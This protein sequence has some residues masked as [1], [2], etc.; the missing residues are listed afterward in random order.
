MDDFLRRSW[1]IPFVAVTAMAV[2]VALLNRPEFT[3][4]PAIYRSR[5]ELLFAGNA[6]Y[7]D[8]YFEHLPLSLVPMMAA[9]LL[10]GFAGDALFTSIFA[11][12]MVACLVGCARAVDEDGGRE[13]GLRWLLLAGPLFPIVIFRSDPFP[14]VLAA[15]AFAA[16]VAGQEK[17]AGGLEFAGVLAKGWPGV[18][19]LVE[20][21]R[22]R[23]GRAVTVAGA[24]VVLLLG[25]LLLPGFRSG[26]AFSGL[27]S[28]TVA[29]AAAIVARTFTGD[30]LG[31]LYEAGATYVSVPVWA[32]VLNL[33]IG[34]LIGLLALGRWRA[35]FTRES[36]AGILS[37]AVVT[38]L[39]ISPVLSPQFLLWPTPFLALHRSRAV[40]GLALGTALLTLVYM[41]GWNPDF[42]GNPWWIVVLNV[43]NLVLVALGV[44]CAWG[45]AAPRPQ[46]LSDPISTMAE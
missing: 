16:V 43:R 29:G 9:W 21:A 6:P 39:L 11:L 35:G 15:A 8:F 2:G 30:S 27:H 7:F 34:V 41:V 14:T 5:M 36:G 3:G 40:K 20:A 4:D 10:G 42:L 46:S 38:L 22:G 23:W 13:A 25:L 12:L 28:E 45:I 18:L 32:W 19:A 44:V 24:G 37:A 26:R 17:K 33:N 1:V 31:L